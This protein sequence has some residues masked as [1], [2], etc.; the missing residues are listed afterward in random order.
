MVLVIDGSGPIRMRLRPI[1][2]KYMQNY[3]QLVT[4]AMSAQL[5]SPYLFR[6]AGRGSALL[7][8]RAIICLIPYV[9]SLT[10]AAR[11][12]SMQKFTKPGV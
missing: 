8:S 4:S 10:V 7:G 5:P 12:T 9:L 11:P 3:S 1:R 2:T 6:K